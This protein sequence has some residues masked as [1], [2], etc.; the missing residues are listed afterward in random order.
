[1]KHSLTYLLSELA[2]YAEQNELLRKEDEAYVMNG[3]LSLMRG[4]EL[5]DEK[6]T[7]ARA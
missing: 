2:L 5:T 4:T 3:W 7:S 6:A 1:M